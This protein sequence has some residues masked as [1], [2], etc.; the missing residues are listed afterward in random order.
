MRPGS[1]GPSCSCGGPR[2]HTAWAGTGSAWPRVEREASDGAPRCPEL[3]GLHGAAGSREGRTARMRP[4][5]AARASLRAGPA[6]GRAA[7]Y[8]RAP[9]PTPAGGR[10]RSPGR[11]GRCGARGWSQAACQ[12]GLGEGRRPGTSAAS[13]TWRVLAPTPGFARPTDLFVPPL[14][15]PPLLPSAKVLPLSLC[16]CLSLLSL[17]PSPLPL[18]EQPGCRPNRAPSAPSSRSLRPASQG[19]SGTWFFFLGHAGSL[20]MTG[21]TGQ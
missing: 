6:P 13:A 2:E 20:G 4:C 3:P 1:R 16:P 10:S 15:S 11:P 17:S 7:I 12:S 8:S 18:L 9:P 5:E 19:L 14:A 21:R